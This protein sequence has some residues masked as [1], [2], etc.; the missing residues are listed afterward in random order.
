VA[1]T[2]AGGGISTGGGGGGTTSGPQGAKYSPLRAP[3]T[4]L[5]AGS[6]DEY[7]GSI[8]TGKFTWGNQGA[9][10]AVHELDCLKF[11]IPAAAAVD[12]KII[13][14]AC[15]A[16][17][18]WVFTTMFTG[19]TGVAV[20]IPGLHGLAALVTGSIAVPTLIEMGTIV[21]TPAEVTIT[22]YN[23]TGYVAG[24]ANALGGFNLADQWMVAGPWAFEQFVF[25]NAS[26]NLAYRISKDGMSWLTV[27]TR[28]ALAA[29]PTHVGFLMDQNTS[30]VAFDIYYGFARTLN[31]AT[32]PYAAG[33]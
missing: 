2:P 17:S 9:A 5:V 3:T 8:D 24:Y 19:A 11:S 28:L 18:D 4:G 27:G 29:N 1:I 20:P 6:S 15:P 22:M 25:L 30:N 21:R 7:V 14:Y 33:G 16:A 23:T 10:T 12:R 26:K 32:A 13:W 31:V